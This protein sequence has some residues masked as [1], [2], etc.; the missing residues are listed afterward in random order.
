MKKNERVLILSDEIYEHILFDG[1]EFV[2]FAAANP[3]LSERILTVNGVSKA[4]A[5]TGWRI[6]YGASHSDLIAAMTK[7]QSQIS[8]GACSIAQA[9]AAAALN[10]PQD[11][12]RRFRDAFESRRNLVVERIAQ[13]EGLTLDPPDGAFYAYIGC[14]ALIGALKPDGSKIEAD[15]DVAA[16]LLE[17]AG[18]ACVP[19]GAYDLSPFFRIS[20][21][22]SE[23]V[24]SD[25]LDRIARAVDNL[26]LTQGNA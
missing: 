20:T 25:A 13:I 5:M 10:G 9:A 26:K 23:D 14:A 4:Y 22:T 2:S 17:A 8:S 12:V 11:D 1:R 3:D 21:A 16:Y 24:L 18:I 7:V 15:S 6:G 19:G